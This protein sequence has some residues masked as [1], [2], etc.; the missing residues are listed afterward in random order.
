MSIEAL[1]KYPDAKPD[2]IDSDAGQDCYRV[3]RSWASE[4]IRVPAGTPVQRH[5]EKAGIRRN[6]T[7]E[8]LHRHFE[9]SYVQDDALVIPLNDFVHR[10]IAGSDPVALAR[11]LWS[12]DE[13]VCEAFMEAMTERYS[14]K[15]LS[16]AQRRRFLTKVQAEVWAASLDKAV[17]T[18]EAK[19]DATRTAYRLQEAIGDLQYI[20]SSIM[21]EIANDGATI[22]DVR[23]SD[24]FDRMS[25]WL[26]RSQAESSDARGAGKDW[27]EARDF[28]RRALVEKFPGPV[29][30]KEE[31]EACKE[32]L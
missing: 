27:R 11:S 17:E 28:W 24:A 20:A 6:V 8:S 18:M 30:V 1:T 2:F 7:H 12:A 25:R 9:N 29:E 32:V 31:A 10:I 15:S 22:E 21:R 16:D 4:I 26:A 19:D 23:H 5:A 13:E 14:D 3:V